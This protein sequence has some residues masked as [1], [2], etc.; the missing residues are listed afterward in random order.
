MAKKQQNEKEKNSAVEKI[1]NIIQKNRKVFLISLGCII[2]GV[3]VLTAVYAINESA[4]KKAV[5][6]LSAFSEQLTKA[7]QGS[8]EAAEI[9]AEMEAFAAKKSGYAGAE[10]YNLIATYHANQKAWEA[11]E[12]AWLKAAAKAPKHYLA[13]SSLFNAGVAAEEQGNNTKAIDYYTQAAEFN[14]VFGGEVRAYWAI[15]RLYEAENN[16]AAALEIYEKIVSDYS[17]DENGLRRDEL[18][19]L[20]Q[21][22]II[23]LSN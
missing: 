14:G 8:S 4:T 12:A 2:L 6:E 15:G 3:I 13:P 1:L 9:I 21:A 22:R 16:P 10:A 18:T 5:A 17:G 23:V 20:A 19:K 11:A 7:D